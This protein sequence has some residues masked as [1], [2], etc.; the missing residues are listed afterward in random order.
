M[1]YE[2]YISW[3]TVDT[4]FVFQERTDQNSTRLSPQYLLK[5][6]MYDMNEETIELALINAVK[7]VQ[8]VDDT[9]P[10]F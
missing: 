4:D 3:T 9:I 2:E 5:A 8:Q 1:V 6:L 7:E 10:C